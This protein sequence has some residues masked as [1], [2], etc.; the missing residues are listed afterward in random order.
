MVLGGNTMSLD[1]RN[2]TSNEIEKNFNP[3]IAVPDFATYIEEAQKK[4]NLARKNLPGK[5]DVD[6]GNH[7]MQ[8][9]DVFGL[10]HLNNAPVHVFIHGGYWR[11][12]DKSD[13]SHL[14]IPF[15]NNNCLYFTLNY[16]LCPNVKLTE[17]NNQIHSAIKW[18][19]KNCH[20]YGGDPQNINISGHSVGAHLC[21]MLLNTKWENNNFPYD[22]IKSAYLI[23][24]IFEPEVVLK[25]SLNE[26]IGLDEQEVASNTPIPTSKVNSKIFLSAGD[27]EPPGWIE[28]TK[29]YTRKLKEK[30]NAVNFQILKKENHFSIL[31]VLSDSNNK[32]T[33]E[34]ITVTRDETNE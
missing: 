29:I 6:Y 4:A 9:L 11:A 10:E 7:P 5:L 34:M 26:E 33:K 31:N 13:H 22:I 14:A 12:L 24:G 3:R 27:I 1:W 30:G 8:K 17:I 16:G 25:L 18:I 2:F 32:F 23:S 28:Q 21:A 20:K 19:Y 15:V